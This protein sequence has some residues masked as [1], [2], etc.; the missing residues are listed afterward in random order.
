MDG[1]DIPHLVFSS[2]IGIPLHLRY[3]VQ[4]DVN[5]DHLKT[6]IKIKRKGFCDVAAVYLV[7]FGGASTANF[8]HLG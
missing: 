7:C 4:A 8:K 6:D 5:I 1:E 3:T 2:L